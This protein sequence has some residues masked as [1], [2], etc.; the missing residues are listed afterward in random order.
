MDLTEKIT[1]VL[2][3][4]FA[5]AAVI[6]LARTP[7][8]LALKV[9]CNT[10]LGLLALWGVNFASAAVGVKLGVNLVNAFVIAVLGVPGLALLLLL[11]WL[12]AV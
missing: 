2:V 3:L 10:L 8:R 12:F 1:L 7:L 9:G 4:G 11:Q 5:L 6:R